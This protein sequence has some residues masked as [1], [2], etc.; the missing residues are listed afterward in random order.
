M[1][2]LRASTIRA[3]RS[4]AVN[5]KHQQASDPSSNDFGYQHA[6]H[7]FT[8]NASY[9]RPSRLTKIETQDASPGP[10]SEALPSSL[11]PHILWIRHALF[12]Q[13]SA[14]Q[15]SLV[16]AMSR[17]HTVRHRHPAGM[18]AG[19]VWRRW[20]RL[21]GVAGFKRS[22]DPAIALHALTSAF[23]SPGRQYSRAMGAGAKCGHARDRLVGGR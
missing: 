13:Q 21:Q 8:T 16:Y 18:V 5:R 9:A 14:R 10:G 22:R 11:R 3:T 2:L 4:S 19:R 15:T 7:L 17:A 1:R 12:D 20:H 23:V 6:R